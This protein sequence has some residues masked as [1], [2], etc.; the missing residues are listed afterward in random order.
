MYG[1]KCRTL[2]LWNEMGER[3]VFG[4][5]ILQEAERQV[6]MVRDNLKVVQS[7][8]KSYVDHRRRNI[9]FEVRDFI[10]RN[11]SPMRGLHQFKV[12]GKLAPRFIGPIK[13][14]DWR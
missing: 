1:H 9:S 6:H 7:K 13:V 3:Q 14:L 5:D 10:Y 12:Q 2:I 11:V 8:H 4:L